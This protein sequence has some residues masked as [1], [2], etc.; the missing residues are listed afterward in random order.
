[1]FRKKKQVSRLEEVGHNVTEFVQDTLKHAPE[2]LEEVKGSVGDALSHVK[3]SV[4]AQRVEDLKAGVHSAFSHLKGAVAALEPKLE[5]VQGALQNLQRHA[6][7]VAEDAAATATETLDKARKRAKKAKQQARDKAAAMH[8]KAA[9]ARDKAVAMRDDLAQRAE[10]EA[11][12]VTIVSSSEKWL[13]LAIGI[14]I[15]AVIGVLVAPTS[16]RRSRALIR[17]K[18]SKGGH[19]ASDLGD[20]ATSKVADAGRRAKGLAHDVGDKFSGAADDAD[21]NTIADRV[22]TALGENP[23]TAGLERLN[24]DCVDGIVTLRGPVVTAVQ[25]SAIESLV[26]GV[27]GVREVRSELLV[28]DDADETETFVG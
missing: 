22:R 4:N 11:P 28:E 14:A 21:D 16:G 25:Q 5:M 18:F 3:E 2:K 10:E 12:T 17:D 26:Y 27:K 8:D 13:W 23:A 15:G 6:P 20:V 9:A 1:M 7:E 24:V 19:L